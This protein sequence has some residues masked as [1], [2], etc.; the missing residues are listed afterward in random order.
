MEDDVGDMVRCLF[1]PSAALAAPLDTPND[2]D[3]SAAAA[4]PTEAAKKVNVDSPMKD[5]TTV[6][7]DGKQTD[8]GVAHFQCMAARA[9][10]CKIEATSIAADL[11][12]GTTVKLDAEQIGQLNPPGE[13]IVDKTYRGARAKRGGDTVN[14]SVTMTIDPSNLTCI[15]CDVEH[16]VIQGQTKPV[17]VV[18]ADQ[19]FVPIWPNCTKESC[20]VVIRLL[21]PTLHELFDLLLEIFD[22]NML[23]DGS[24]VLSSSVSYLHR[25]G[26]SYYAREWTQVVNRMGRR[27]PNVRVCPLPP[28]IRSTCSGG[29]ARELIELGGWLANVYKNC[30]QGLLEV[31]NSLA[32]ITIE[33]SAGQTTLN[34]VEAYTITLPEKL[35]LGAPDK[36]T[37]LYTNS[38]RPS[39]LYGIDQGTSSGLLHTLSNVLDRDFKIPV[40][41]GIKPASA[42]TAEGVQENVKR[43]VLV[44]ASNL[45]RVVPNLK[46]E[47]FE[48]LDLCTP[49]WTVTPQNIQNLLG[50][51]KNSNFSQNCAVVFDLFGNSCFRA[52]LFDGSTI[53]PIREGGGYHLPGTVEVCK[54]DIFV[55]LVELVQP[56]LDAVES[57]IRLVIPPQ[58]RYLYSPCCSDRSHCSNVGQNSHAENL[59]AGCF[60]L[61]S[62]LKRKLS[63][64][65]AAIPPWVMDT[66]CGVH[67]TEKTVI[68]KQE[69]LKQISSY[70]GVHL[71]AEG[72]GNVAKNICGAIKNLQNGTQ[73]KAISMSRAAAVHVA[74]AE[75]RHFWKGFSSPVGSAKRSANQSW[76]KFP[77]EKS[78]GGNIPY[79]RWGRGGKSYWKN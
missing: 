28:L 23:P 45:K 50:I 79:R 55:K 34:A 72:N 10:S 24:M 65:G 19:N 1:G 67:G 6:D 20:V 63:V 17:V 29:V 41:T 47:G 4:I 13:L 74:G 38:S 30:P 22:R 21:N 36:P 68:E 64:S 8:M 2:P 48:V 60:R 7:M 54:D 12:F 39:V 16:P 46:N 43:V 18:L 44:G 62:I 57:T 42:R 76:G 5:S 75:P 73:G 35:D 9:A 61:R 71:T 59:L 31:W 49:G 56:V 27:L 58:P 25:V 69:V 15:T 3:G 14:Q 40:G 11:T 70:D 26:T 37:T 78:H 33:R 66:C 53:M 51:L 32:S 77:K 52:S